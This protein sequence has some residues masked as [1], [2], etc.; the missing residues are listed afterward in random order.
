MQNQANWLFIVECQKWLKGWP[1]EEIEKFKNTSQQE[2]RHLHHGLGTAIRN[3]FLW[4]KTPNELR[5][6]EEELFAA[7]FVGRIT[8]GWPIDPDN[9]SGGIIRMLHDYIQQN[10]L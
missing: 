3:E 1:I 10:D 8:K 7:G 6:I 4:D 5:K 9:L 2:L